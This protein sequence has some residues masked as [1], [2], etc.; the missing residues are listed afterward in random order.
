MTPGIHKIK[1]EL[2]HAGQGLSSSNLKDL[3]RSAAHFQAAKLE[4]MEPT[5]QMV[6]GS[7]FHALVLEPECFESDYAVG[8]HT[9]RRGKEYE[10]CLADNPGKT[11]ITAEQFRAA[12]AM[13]DSYLAQCQG[14]TELAELNDGLKETAFYWECQATGALC[15]VKPDLIPSKGCVIAD[16]KTASD[17]SFD[18][19]QRQMVDLQYFVSAAFYLR[20]V[21]E[22]MRMGIKIPNVSEVPTGFK[23]IVIE[24]KEPYPVAI[25]RLAPKALEFGNVL[26]DR[27]LET[28]AEAIATD[29]WPGYSKQALEM[30][31]PAYAYYKA[32]Y[33]GG[34]L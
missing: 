2:Y 15:K 19:F 8:E 4:P 10:R 20:G 28:Y 31:L 16:L 13:R 34:S 25:Y 24:T 12:C 21:A 26:I 22:V 23:F 29:T 27:A 30:D 18:T 7:V 32:N 17:A 14:N 6:L 1:N 3:L 11:I 5:P 33:V 9:V